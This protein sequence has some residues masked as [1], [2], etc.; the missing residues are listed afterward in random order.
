MKKILIVCTGNSCRSI[1]A[2]GYLVHRLKELGL[3]DVIVA[4]AGTGA[5]GG[6]HPTAETVEVMKESSIDVS[7]YTSSPLERSRIESADIILV[8]ESAHKNR[9]IIMSPDTQDK[10]FFLREFSSEKTKNIFIDDPIGKSIEF[11]R[12]VSAVI[13][14][15]TEGFIKQWLK[16]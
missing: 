10:I 4:S 13:K 15:S 1:M 5:M 16:K 9:I 14:N 11:Y 2:E 6:F 3:E 7:G 8:M 12:E